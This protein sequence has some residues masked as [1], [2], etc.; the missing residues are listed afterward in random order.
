MAADLPDDLLLGRV[1]RIRHLPSFAVH[2][3]YDIVYP[4]RNLDDLRRAWPELDW[5]IVADA[6]HSSHEPGITRELVVATSR[7]AATGSPGRQWSWRDPPATIGIF[8]PPAPGQE[9]RAWWTRRPATLGA[10][11][12][13][14]A[15]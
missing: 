8:G 3:R 1:H 15:G 14:G 10:P 2:G 13:V 11:T 9:S 7:I 4:V 12:R 6:G 5:T